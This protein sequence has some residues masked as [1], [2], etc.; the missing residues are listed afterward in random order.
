MSQQSWC[1]NGH[2]AFT[3][4]TC[5]ICALIEESRAREERERKEREEEDKKRKAEEERRRLEEEEEDEYEES[6]EQIFTDIG[7]MLACAFSDQ[8]EFKEKCA[9][10]VGMI[11]S[12]Q[13][14]DAESVL[15][16]LI[17]WAERFSSEGHAPESF[18]FPHFL[19]FEVRSFNDIDGTQELVD[20]LM[21]VKSVFVIGRGN[22]YDSS[23]YL[24]DS[25]ADL[26]KVLGR[27][28]CPRNLEI[29]LIEFIKTYA[30]HNADKMT[31]AEAERIRHY[32]WFPWW[33]K[34]KRLLFRQAVYEK[35][36]LRLKN[37]LD[38]A[39]AQVD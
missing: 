33:P 1:T 6:K 8:K 38:A 7:E 29:A 11:L 26:K 16:T 22:D 36:F 14:R 30:A 28:G 20:G 24:G 17:G 10:A 18:F 39:I 23:N 2:G 37:I 35:E 32:N 21:K 34:K 25:F 15:L 9:K 27:G 13:F 31:D 5:P 3:G 12:G 19:L 4:F